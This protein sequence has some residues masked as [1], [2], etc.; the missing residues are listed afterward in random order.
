MCKYKYLKNNFLY[1]IMGYLCNKTHRKYSQNEQ[2]KQHKELKQR[3]K[4]GYFAMQKRLF[5][6]VKPMLSLSESISLR[7]RERFY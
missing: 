3:C 2:L 4:S 7:K 1:L 5:Y 6:S